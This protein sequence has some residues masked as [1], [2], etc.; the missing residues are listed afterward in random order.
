MPPGVPTDLNLPQH[1]LCK[2][3]LGKGAYG[4]VYLCVDTRTKDQQQ[5]AVKVIRNFTWDL[6]CGK[7]IVR[8]VKILAALQHENLMRLTDLP[9]VPSPDFTDVYM[10]MPYMHADLHRMINSRMNLSETHCQAFTCQ[11]L[12]G[13]KYLHS[14]GIVHRDLKPANILVNKDCTLRITDF[15]LARGRMDEGDEW[16]HYVVTRWY[17]AP[18][19]MLLPTSYF[20]AIDLWSVGCI[21]FELIARTPL[22]RGENQID[23]LRKIAETLG[24]DPVE[25]LAWVPDECV[26]EVRSMLRLAPM[27]D[28]PVNS[29]RA[30]L[31]GSSDACLDLLER[32][33][34]KIPTRRISA[35]QALDHPYLRH[36]HDPAG[37]TIAK[38]P[39]V[40][41]VDDYE[42]SERALKDRIYAECFR[43]NPEMWERD[44]EYL[45][46]RGF[47]GPAKA[48]SPPTGERSAPG[49]A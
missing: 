5:V 10:V 15:G 41:D 40:W 44:R 38:R 37:E 43:R 23:M 31:P 42:L 32:F 3:L 17:R 4:E 49:G 13:L 29:L 48:K 46:S 19:L 11:I 27:P 21:H 28:R 12:R 47:Q 20:E 35:V 39:F 9:A 8:E 18:E 6:L 22:F 30:R 2:K 7:R 24:L 26:E 16:T 33:L 34:D 25:D 14:A 36:L 1:L 45:R